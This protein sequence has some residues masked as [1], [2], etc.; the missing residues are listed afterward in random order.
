MSITR[1]TLFKQSLMAGLG[2]SLATPKSGAAT[3]TAG[4]KVVVTIHLYGGNDGLN[5]VIPLNQYDRYRQL[6]PN[7]G[8]DQSVLLT[9]PG[10]SELAFAPGLS[11][12][13]QLYA[14]GKL[15]VLNGVAVPHDATGLYDHAANI[16]S[17]QTSDI[18]H[19]T[20]AAPPTGWLGRYL[21]LVSEGLIP[22]GIDLGGGL[23]PLTGSGGFTPISIGS[24]DDFQLEISS[25]ADARRQSYTALMNISNANYVAEYNR[26][27][28][29]QSLAD[30][31][32][33]QS[34][35]ANYVPAAVYPA[36]NYLAYSLLQCAELIAGNLGV[37]ALTVGYGGFDTHSGQ[38][39]AVYDSTLG[40][41]DDL[42]QTVSEA[43]YA[44]YTDLQAHG[45]ADKVLIVTTSE[46]GRTAYENVDQGTDHGYSSVAFAIG[47]AVKGGIYG[48]YPSLAEADLFDAN[49]DLTTDFRSV[50]A[51]IAANFLNTDPVPMVGGSFPLLGFV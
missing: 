43:I 10:Q 29:L 19:I 45:L 3:I 12:F 33:I 21:D 30:S 32:I 2:L 17:Y 16:F 24:I 1:R 50:Y 51:T 46:F 20:T 42:W 11:A 36:D 41:H 22:A 4:N 8:Y 26:Q 23:L 44:F 49:T 6:R 9:L 38:N 47:G 39:G 5:T 15:A 37:S 48:D 13:N 40:Y 35:T 14:Q 34:N 25:D 27:L 31:A 7:L 18:R 28:K